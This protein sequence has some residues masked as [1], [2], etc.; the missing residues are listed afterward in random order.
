VPAAKWTVLVT[1]WTSEGK[2][3]NISVPCVII[4]TS[5]EIKFVEFGDDGK[6]LPC[7]NSVSL[8]SLLFLHWR[9]PVILFRCFKFISCV[10]FSLSCLLLHDDYRHVYGYLP[11]FWGLE[12]HTGYVHALYFVC[13]RM[14]Y[15]NIFQVTIYLEWY[16]M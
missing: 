14:L 1:L 10:Q 11:Q 6:P 3:V 9:R 4:S 12:S 2:E 16:C 7:W 5:W 13:L 15:A 8:L